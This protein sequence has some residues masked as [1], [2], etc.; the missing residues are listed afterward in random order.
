[1]A[2][3]MLGN[4]VAGAANTKTI[5]N[6]SLNGDGE[7]GST[8]CSPHGS[9]DPCERRRS[10]HADDTDSRSCSAYDSDDYCH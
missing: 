1:M 9:R 7:V 10:G 5:P 6:V 8:L 4:R 2:R 3:T